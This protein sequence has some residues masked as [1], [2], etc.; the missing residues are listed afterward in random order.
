LQTRGS[1][2]HAKYIIRTGFPSFDS[3]RS[4]K[5]TRA[6]TSPWPIFSPINNSVVYS[7]STYFSANPPRRLVT[8][9]EAADNIAKISWFEAEG[10]SSRGVELPFSGPCIGYPGLPS[11]ITEG[12]LLKQYFLTTSERRLEKSNQVWAVPQLFTRKHQ[13][14]DRTASS[15]V[16]CH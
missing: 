8:C 1:T 14:K 13:M 7:N 6:S 16:L 3:A 10:I 4:W 9:D 12:Y 15:L 11:H 2:T 5:D